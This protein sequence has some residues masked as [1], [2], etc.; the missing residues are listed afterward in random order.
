MIKSVPK[1]LLFIVPIVLF[2]G[3]ITKE[4]VEKPDAFTVRGRI[5]N[6]G[7]PQ[8]NVTIDLDNLVQYETVSDK[9][10]YFEVKNVSTGSHTLN[11]NKTL[12]NSAYSKLGESIEVF[13]NL[14]L[15]NLTL[16]EPVILFEPTISKTIKNNTVT[17]RWSKY[18]GSDY[19]EYKLYS[20]DNTGLDETTGELIHVATSADDTTFTLAMAHGQEKY[21][22]LFIK[23]EFGLLGGSNILKISLD[24][25]H[26]D[27]QILVGVENAY[28]LNNEETLLLHFEAIQGDIYIIEK[29]DGY[30]ANYFE[31][32][33]SGDYTANGVTMDALSQ[34]LKP[35]YFV[36]IRLEV[37]PKIIIAQKTERVY[38]RIRGF[39]ERT[40]GTFGIKVVK[41]DKTLSI[42]LSVGATSFYDIDGL[43]VKLF[44]FDVIGGKQYQFSLGNTKG[45][46]GYLDWIMTVASAYN[47]NSGVAYFKEEYLHCMSCGWPPNLFVIS[48]T[49]SHRVYLSI[50]GQ[51]Q[52]GNNSYLPNNVRIILTEL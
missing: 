3:C 44:H 24:L 20:H 46:D 48:P 50:G 31:N 26:S 43:D 49:E 21:F 11:F 18:T 30:T 16:P 7:V 13:D 15:D 36:N 4:L 42:P 33:G 1:R 28:F 37:S 38:I 27:P 6:K 2:S 25:Y 19:R 47:G 45:K 17:L 14:T 35:A 39:D 23:D 9:N 51:P 5:T 22:R 40:A 10:G 34:D 8:D 52:S 29:Y 12:S 41:F 32:F